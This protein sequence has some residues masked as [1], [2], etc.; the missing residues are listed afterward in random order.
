[1]SIDA[2]R[3]GLITNEFRWKEEYNPTL[4]AEYIKARELIIETNFDFANIPLLLADIFGVIGA[5]RRRFILDIK[6]TDYIG[7]DDFAV[8]TPARYFH[9]PEHSANML[10]VI[11]TRAAIMESENRTTMELWG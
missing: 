3:Y 1:M 5:T 4:A 11:I 2:A 9:A 8:S 6:G 7:I 10:P